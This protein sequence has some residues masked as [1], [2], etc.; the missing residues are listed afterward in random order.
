[1]ADEYVR[2]YTRYV[3]DELKEKIN[4]KNLQLW[5]TYL[6]G[7]RKLADSTREQYSYD[8]QQ[9]FVYILKEYDNQYLFDIDEMDMA[10]I[11]ED[12]ISMCVFAFG[13][14]DRRICRRMSTISSMYI[15]YK[16]KRKIK[17]NPV[18]LLE[19]P[20]VK[21]GIGVMKQ[22]FL[23]QEQVNQI[24]NKLEEENDVQLTLFFELGIYTMLRVNAL[25]N[26][27]VEN[28]DFEKKKIVDI[29]EKEGY[30]VTASLSDKCISLIKEWIENREQDSELLF[31]N[32]NGL[33][34]KDS[35]QGIW[36]KRIGYF[37]GVP[38]LHCHDLRHSGSDLRFKA[39]QS[40]ES[41][42][43]ALNHAGTDVTQKFYLTEDEE[44]LAEEMERFEV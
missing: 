1:M 11:L 41:V 16:K 28:I 18:E 22:T 35:M 19:R 25:S 24:R 40:L 38:T 30:I 12:F 13:N 43:K 6:N 9:F 34:A 36:I 21:A 7:K 10:D 44:K 23:T 4:P 26:I 8:M 37:V 2:K 32:R 20:E 33:N 3:T 15:H 27:R 14:S 31:V 42:S 39:G 5:K 29:K 17:F